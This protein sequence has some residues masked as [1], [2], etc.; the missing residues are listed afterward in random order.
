LSENKTITIVPLSAQAQQRRRQHHP[1]HSMDSQDAGKTK[2]S[3]RP[4]S[5]RGRFCTAF[6]EGARI[7]VDRKIGQIMASGQDASLVSSLKRAWKRAEQM[8]NKDP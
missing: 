6:A 3:H 7:S 4:P 5:S 2:T 8:R 1:K